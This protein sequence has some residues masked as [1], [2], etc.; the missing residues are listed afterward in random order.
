MLRST[1][2]EYRTCTCTCTPHTG[3]HL[4]ID[5]LSVCL[6]LCH[7]LSVSVTHTR[8][9]SYP[10][11][12]LRIDSLSVSIFLSLSPI[13]TF[14]CTPT[15]WHMHFIRTRLLRLLVGSEG[16]LDAL[17]L[18]SK[19]ATGRCGTHARMI[20]RMRNHYDCTAVTYAIGRE[21]S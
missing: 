17:V 15:Y 12:H 16:L 3:T 6:C 14:T 13:L 8:P 20:V 7:P 2:T 21:V 11:T 9:H 19:Q 1:C 4:L 5:S 10:S 18:G